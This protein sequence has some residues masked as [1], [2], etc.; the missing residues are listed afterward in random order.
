MLQGQ[1]SWSGL[2]QLDAWGISGQGSGPPKGTRNLSTSSK[3][4]VIGSSGP[5]TSLLPLH[6]SSAE[7]RRSY[8]DEW[9]V[10]GLLTA[11]VATLLDI[12]GTPGV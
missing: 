9:Q 1:V 2:N 10:Q 8:L 3:S 11:P 12:G 5:E 7:Q 4:R 6:I